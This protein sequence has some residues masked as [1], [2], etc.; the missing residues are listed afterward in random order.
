LEKVIN[1]GQK[2]FVAVGLAL[3]EIRDRRLYKPEFKTVEND[4]REKWGWTRQWAYEPI[5]ASEAVRLLPVECNQKITN[6]PQ[7]R[8]LRSRASP[9]AATEAA[10]LLSEAV[11]QHVNHGLQNERYARAIARVPAADRAEVLETAVGGD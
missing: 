7:A 9:R 10:P 6:D 8:E 2:G 11:N 4:C 3:A 5:A 1:R